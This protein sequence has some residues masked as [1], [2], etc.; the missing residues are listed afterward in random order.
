LWRF[1]K[2][3]K[4]AIGRSK[5]GLTTKIHMMCANERKAVDFILSEGQRHDAPQGRLL[6][7]TVDKPDNYTPLL[8]DRAYEDDLTRYTA[9]ILN[10]RPIVPPK[11]NR[12]RPWKYDKTLYKRRNEIERL[13]RLLC[14]F[15][16]IFCRYEKLDI[17]FIGF[18]HLALVF[19][20]IS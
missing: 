3:G 14:G 4:Q 12:K 6:M 7:E 13:F 1:K 8:M 20:S 16:R 11:K 19:V 2:N 17:M 9:Q 15:R 10:F 5:G 18:I